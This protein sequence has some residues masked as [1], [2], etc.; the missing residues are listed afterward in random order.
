MSLL[1]CP[2]CQA[3]MREVSRE[4][5]AID[6]CTQC[7]G[8]WLDRGELE[9]LSAVLLQSASQAPA[10]FLGSSTAYAPRSQAEPASRQRYRRDDD[11]DDD[12]GDDRRFRRRGDQPD[13]RKSKV[14]RLLDFFD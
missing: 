14:S 9:K 8:V 2:V 7:R 6:T 10:S 4:G 13:P 12:D 1:N 5:V 11:D 3:P